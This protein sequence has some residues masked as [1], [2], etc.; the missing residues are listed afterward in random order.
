M[1]IIRNIKVPLDEADNLRKICADA[2]RCDSQLIKS[3]KLVKRSVDAR[4][5]NNGHFVYTLLADVADEFRLVRRCKS[6]EIYTE[7]KDEPLVPLRDR[8]KLPPVVVGSG[9]AGLFAALTLAQNGYKPILIE[10]GKSVDDRKKAVER[11]WCEHLLDTETNV[12]FGEGGA[13]TFS[14]GKLNTGTKDLRIKQVL[15]TFAEFGAPENILY[16]AQPHIGTDLLSEVIKNIRNCIIELGGSVMFETKLT[17]ITFENGVKSVT[18]L[19]KSGE[20]KIECD[21]VVLAIG[22][23]ARDTFLMLEQK[24]VPMEPKP[25]SVGVRIEHLQSSINLARYG[26]FASHR[27]LSAAS[28]KL[29]AHIGDRGVYTFCMCPGGV[30]VAAASEP[31]TVVTNGMSYNARDGKN[32]N[33][34]LLVGVGQKDFG[35]DDALAGV[36]FQQMLE[37]KAFDLSGSYKAPCQRVG[38]FLQNKKT[39]TFGSVKP[40]FTAGVEAANICD[41]LPDYVTDTIKQGLSEFGKSINGFDA[42]DA[43]LTAPETR[44]SSPVRILRDDSLQ[45]FRGLYP[46]GE[47]AGYAGGIMSAAVDGIRCAEKIMLTK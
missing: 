32:A 19:S 12:Q 43:V 5:K 34:A 47:G 33:S 20:S 10:R 40:S 22:H 6:A 36:R 35:G 42:E 37:R 25:F 29:A 18:C 45:S 17:D 46:C 27:A 7:P 39:A 8:S 13:G 23:S 21:S 2:L 24:G 15:S 4:K 30:V 16:D 41:I 31:E 9:P 28:Y 38:D 14:D 1:I 11:F 44:S 3:C 26:D